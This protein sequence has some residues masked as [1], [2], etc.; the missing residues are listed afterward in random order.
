[1]GQSSKLPYRWVNDGCE[2]YTKKRASKLRRARGNKWLTKEFDRK[3]IRNDGTERD[4][5]VDE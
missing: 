4:R 2:P 5:R 3:V 1:M